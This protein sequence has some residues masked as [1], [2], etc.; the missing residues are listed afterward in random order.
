[1]V[2]F[3]L[4]NV[5]AFLLKLED[6]LIPFNVTFSDFI[7]KSLIRTENFNKKIGIERKKN[8]MTKMRTF[9]K[10]K[11]KSFFN[12]IVFRDKLKKEEKFKKFTDIRS[13]GSYK[14]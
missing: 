9:F 2:D 4:V 7:P 13:S 11:F 14:I 3:S 1:M 8:A 10:K 12:R 6:D 5:E